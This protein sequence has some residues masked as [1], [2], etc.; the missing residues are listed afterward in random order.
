MFATPG[1]ALATTASLVGGYASYQ[2]AVASNKAAAA[3]AEAIG[4]ESQLVQ[5]QGI[6]AQAKKAQ[7]VNQ[8]AGAEE[9]AYA[10]SGIDTSRGTGA[11]IKKQTLTA[12][13]ADIMTIQSNTLNQMNALKQQQK[14]Y[15]AQQVNPF[16]S[17]GATVLTDMAMGGVF[18]GIPWTSS[19][20]KAASTGKLIGGGAI[21]P[22]V[23]FTA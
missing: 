17:A 9:A 13:N 3:N 18:K 19:A 12:G 5:Q 10:S 23:A 15:L 7:E 1:A 2:G 14:G 8:I 16:L 20:S 6:Q 4:Q 21:N 11:D 22:S